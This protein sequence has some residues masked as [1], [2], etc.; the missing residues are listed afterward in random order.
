MFSTG[1]SSDSDVQNLDQ[2]ALYY[3]KFLHMAETQE[4]LPTSDLDKE[5]PMTL[6]LSSA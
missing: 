2:V 1:R 6:S 5:T 3:F 4:H